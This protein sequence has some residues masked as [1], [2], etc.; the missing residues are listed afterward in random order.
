MHKHTQTETKTVTHHDT[1]DTTP[2]EHL[3]NATTNIL[4]TQRETVVLFAP[5]A[6]PYR[7]QNRIFGGKNLIDWLSNVTCHNTSASAMSY[8]VVCNAYMLII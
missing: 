3:L 7:L 4:Q 6:L 8:R 2:A 1:A 5:F